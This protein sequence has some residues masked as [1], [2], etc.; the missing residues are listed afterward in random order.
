MDGVLKETIGFED[1]ISCSAMIAANLA[2]LGAIL[3]VF[4]LITNP[5]PRLALR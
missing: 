1:Q 4:R 2:I 3:A 5:K